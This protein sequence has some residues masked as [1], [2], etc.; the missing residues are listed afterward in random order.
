MASIVLP[1]GVGDCMARAERMAFLERYDE[2]L[3]DFSRSLLNQIEYAPSPS[4]NGCKEQQ[5]R[6]F[7]ATCT[8]ITSYLS[9]TGR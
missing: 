7:T 4:T 8:S 6:F 3:D 5:S 9:K 2:K 1:V